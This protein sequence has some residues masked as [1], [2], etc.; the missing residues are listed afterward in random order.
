MMQLLAQ[1]AVSMEAPAG[2]A[3]SPGA[4]VS[5]AAAFIPFLALLGCVLSGL[6]AAFRVK[7]KLPAWLTVG[8]LGAAFVYRAVPVGAGRNTVRFTYRS[9]AFPWLVVVS[10]GTLAIVLLAS[11]APSDWRWRSIGGHYMRGQ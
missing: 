7:S 6:C 3:G 1:H 10:W 5:V 9:S 4:H 8:C 11:V 2:W